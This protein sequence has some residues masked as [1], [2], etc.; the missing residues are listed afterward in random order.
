MIRS[1]IHLHMIRITNTLIF[2]CLIVPL[3]VCNSRACG[4]DSAEVNEA[5]Y[6]ITQKEIRIPMSDGTELWGCLTHPDTM[7]EAE[8][9]PALLVMDPYA[10]ECSLTY[11]YE[12]AQARQGYAVA[13]VH[14]RGSG[15]SEG[16]FMDREHSRQ[17][18]NDA[19]EVINWLASRPWSTG[20]V[21]MYGWSWSGFNALQVAMKKP[22]PLKAI[23][24]NVSTENLYHE[25]VHYAD[26]IFRFGT[27]NMFADLN[28]I[29]TPPPLNPADDS[30][31][32]RRFDQ[33]PLSLRYL[34]EQTDGP[35][36]RKSIRLDA[37]PDTLQI[38]TYMIGGWYDGYRSAIARTL[39][40]AK[41]PTKAVIG[42]WA[43]SLETPKPEADLAGLMVRWW[44]YW[45]KDEHT[46]VMDDPDLITYMRTP[47]LPAAA[48]DTIP[49]QWQKVE[50]WPPDNDRRTTYYLSPGHELQRTKSLSD[51]LKLRYIPTA[52]AE[53]G[54]WWGDVLADQRP[55]EARSLTFETSPFKK[56]QA[57]LGRPQARLWVSATARHA[58]WIVRL[59]DVAP[60]RASPGPPGTVRT[61]IPVPI[62][63]TWN[64][65][66]NMPSISRS[67]LQV[68]YSSPGI[69]CESLYPMRSGPCSGLLRIP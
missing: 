43:H 49:G 11:Y 28:L 34:K 55:A 15:H 38:P 35:F 1:V 24:A 8:K 65:V 45:L 3:L 56:E 46:G 22:E 61:A 31:L 68:G 39:Q 58:N 21:G 48:T 6:S 33:P 32:A 51:T 17:E 30:L 2:L 64:R 19:I 5:P 41:A 4:Q 9:F 16:T 69:K 26:G 63:S 23:I 54:I 13:Y 52:G 59:S 67:I 60:L 40:Y 57:L 66:K 62:P 53:A 14:V 37:N 12:G 25:D 18:L 47:Y 44:D 50:Q 10:G 36:W 20:K 29:Y 7:D 27:Y 42:P